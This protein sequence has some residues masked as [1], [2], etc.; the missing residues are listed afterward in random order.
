MFF[1]M[2]MT[3]AAVSSTVK[4]GLKRAIEFWA[5]PGDMTLVLTNGTVH[6]YIMVMEW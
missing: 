2:I 4:T 3:T 5:T 6:D 1:I